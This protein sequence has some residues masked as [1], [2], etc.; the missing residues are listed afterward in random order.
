MES[1]IRLKGLKKIRKILKF[2]IKVT[3]KTKRTLKRYSPLA[4]MTHWHVEIDVHNLGKVQNVKEQRKIEARSRIHYCRGRAISITYYE[5]VSVAIYIYISM[6][7]ACVALYCLLWPVWLCH[8]FP[9]YLT[10]GAIFRKKSLLI[11][12]C[13]L[14]FCTTFSETFLILRRNEQDIIINV[15]RSSCK[16]PVILLRF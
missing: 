14:I 16:V 6:Q 3:L 15:H 13:V 5:R 4:N 7:S 9:H 8:I 1:T 11:I 2:I 10:N 12:K